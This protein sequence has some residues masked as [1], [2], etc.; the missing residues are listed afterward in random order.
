MWFVLILS[1][2]YNLSTFGVL[3]LRQVIQQECSPG[4]D[5]DQQHSMLSSRFRVLRCYLGPNPATDFFLT[6]T[7]NHSR[8]V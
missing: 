8:A 3:Y 7:R 6:L 1:G 2:M 5:S 4:M